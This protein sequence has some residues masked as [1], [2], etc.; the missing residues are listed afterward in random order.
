[1]SEIP[2]EVIAN[3]RRLL[4]EALR[5]ALTVTPRKRQTKM[6]KISDHVRRTWVSAGCFGESVQWRLPPPKK[7]KKK[8]KR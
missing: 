2:P 8:K 4:G 6:R 3:E 5:A 1:M 7:K